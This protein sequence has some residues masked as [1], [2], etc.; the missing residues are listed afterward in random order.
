MSKNEAASDGD[1]SGLER[2]RPVAPPRVGPRRRRPGVIALGVVLIAGGGVGGSMLYLHNGQRTPVLTVVRHIPVGA[3]IT[4]AD[5]GEASVALDPS[6]RA[7]P[8]RDRGSVVG[9]RAAA[10]LTPGSLLSSS[11]V[12]TATLLK[13]GEQLVPVGL[14]PEQV[15]ASSGTFL[16]PG[17]QV[18]IVQVPGENQPAK[19]PG[20]QADGQPISARVV[21]VGAPAPGTGAVV[22]DVAVASVDGPRLAGWVSSGNARILVN[23]PGDGA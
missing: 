7:V 15:P 18:Q 8:S 14:K 4:D 16:F 6:I 22:V 12:T 5:L 1:V 21:Q 2:A 23:A 19:T 11:Q 3:T 9:K 10:A 17:A 13:S 20:A